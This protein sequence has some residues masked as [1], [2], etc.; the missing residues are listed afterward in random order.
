MRRAEDSPIGRFVTPSCERSV[1]RLADGSLSKGNVRTIIQQID[2]LLPT[3]S[4]NRG[5]RYREKS[6]T[7]MGNVYGCL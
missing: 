7:Y 6:L 3:K 5:I 1:A 2:G 4:Y